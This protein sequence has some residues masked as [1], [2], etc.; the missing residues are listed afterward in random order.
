VKV[1]K[2]GEARRFSRAAKRR[3]SPRSNSSAAKAPP[4]AVRTR[5]AA[6]RAGPQRPVPCMRKQAGSLQN[7]VVLP[8]RQRG[9]GGVFLRAAVPRQAVCRQVMYVVGRY[10]GTRRWGCGGNGRGG[11]QW[12]CA[13]RWQAQIGGVC[14]AQRQVRHT[15]AGSEHSV[16]RRGVARRREYAVCGR[17]PRVVRSVAARKRCV[18]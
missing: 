12:V 11:R 1:E 9:A 13:R 3:Y 5:Q 7:P 16:R 4:A 8:A 10:G 14:G 6:M 2:V 15:R 18:G 17:A